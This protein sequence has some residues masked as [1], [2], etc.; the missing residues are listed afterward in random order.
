MKSVQLAPSSSVA[1]LVG[2]FSVIDEGSIEVVPAESQETP[3]YKENSMTLSEIEQKVILATLDQCEG[4]RT[5]TASKLG[6]SLRTLRNKLRS[7]GV[8]NVSPY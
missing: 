3:S 5:R 6:I 1:V 8:T 4:N 7:Y 2:N